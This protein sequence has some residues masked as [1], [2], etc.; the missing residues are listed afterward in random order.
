MAKAVT[1]FP[2]RT[3]LVTGASA[4]IGKAMAHQLAASGVDLIV[5]ARD[6]ER[7]NQE[8]AL[9]KGRHN[10][11]VDVLAADLLD[12]AQLLLVEERVRSSTNPV[13]L[14]VNNAAFGTNGDFYNLPID[15]EQREITVN[16]IAP[17]RLAHAALGQ[18][19][20]RKLG[21]ILNISSMSALL[22]GPRMATYAATKSYITSFTESLHVELRGTGVS[23]TASHPGFTRTEFQERAGM[24]GKVDEVPNSMWMSAE[25]VAAESLR[26]AAR[27]S[28]FYVTGRSNS[29]FATVLGILPRGMRRSL[30]KQMRQ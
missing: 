2:W 17:V 21:T 9:L 29:F 4:G 30:S 16:V 23:V 1:K 3:A 22:P 12:P 26:A 13:D 24:Q 18:M 27:G 6:R 28:V 11:R 7:L 10:V 25:D 5:V 20:P 8:A 14:L 15:G 19:L